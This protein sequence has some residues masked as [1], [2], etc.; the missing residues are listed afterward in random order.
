MTKAPI[1]AVCWFAWV[2]QVSDSPE[3]WPELVPPD[4]R[5]LGSRMPILDGC[6][7]F[8]IAS[9]LPVHRWGHG[10]FTIDVSFHPLAST[11]HCSLHTIDI[12]TWRVSEGA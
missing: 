8:L 2:E 6:E 5:N 9:R 10:R 1:L 12:A 11:G 3:G 4:A 7:A